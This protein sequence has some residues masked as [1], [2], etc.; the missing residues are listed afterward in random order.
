MHASITDTRQRLWV[1]A[2]A[3][4]IVLVTVLAYG[5]AIHGGYIWDDREYVWDNGALRSAGGLHAIWCA[6]RSTPMYCPLTFTTFWLEYQLWGVTALGYHITNV[7]LHVINS[8]LVWALLRRLAVA[9]AF[10]AAAIFALHPVHVESVAWVTERKDVLCAMFYLLTTLVWLRFVEHRRWYS[11]ALAFVLFVSAM[12]SKPIA[13][14]LPPVLLLLAW[15]KEPARWRREIPYVVPL[16]VIG[17]ALGLVTVWR[18]RFD[19]PDI[20][21]GPW[22]L[23]LLER[24]LLAG[25]AV[26]FYVGKLLWPTNLMTIYPLWKI[27]AGAPQQYVFPVAALA[28]LAGLWLY[29]QRLGAAPFVAAAYFVMTLG[30]VLGLLN[31]AWTSYVFDHLQY[32]PSI[33]LI[34]LFAA[35]ASGVAARTGMSARVCAVGAAAPLLVLVLLTW[36]QGKIYRSEESL[37]RANLAQNPQAWMAQYNLGTLLMEQG[38]TEEAVEHLEAA[39]RINPDYGQAHKNLG[40]IFAG[41][42]KLDD[43]IRHFAEVVRIEPSVA[44]GQSNWGLALAMQGKLDEAIQHY[45]TALQINPNHL[46]AHY[47][48]G[49]ALEARGAIGDAIDQYAAA[50]RINPDSA[51]ARESL[52]R[53]LARRAA[54]QPQ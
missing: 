30:P 13:C 25:R 54:G 44:D 33:G 26:W 7:A 16:L 50:V 36:S 39:V 5:P 53:A 27:D 14:T 4:L 42:G 48:L 22:R 37:W 49:H 9:G 52:Q 31:F 11:Y 15:W 29:R 3:V 19:T 38:K 17:I 40:T 20:L 45:R 21:P 12:L 35:F 8:L 28:V 46:M 34:A 6:P 23:S 2:G 41:Q 10:F 51:E 32:L 47:N 24:A 1:L 18:Q 43:A